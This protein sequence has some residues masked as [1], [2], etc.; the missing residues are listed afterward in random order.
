M[1]T[2]V[3]VHMFCF[4]CWAL[5]CQPATKFCSLLLW[6]R[7]SADCQLLRYVAFLQLRQ[8]CTCDWS[9]GCGF[10]CV[11][12]LF[13]TRTCKPESANVRTCSSDWT[14]L[15]VDTHQSIQQNDADEHS[16]TPHHTN[17]VCRFYPCVCVNIHMTCALIRPQTTEVIAVKCM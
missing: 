10:N 5:S 4:V 2:T 7:S 8:L 1:L 13:G 9:V 14:S 11:L 17:Q 6:C 16:S 15:A 12:S 3:S